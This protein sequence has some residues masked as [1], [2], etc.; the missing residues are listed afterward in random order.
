MGLIK[1]AMGATGGVLA[2][3]WKEFFYLES[4]PA[5]VLVSKGQ[6]R[7]SGR[8]SNIRGEENIITSGSGIAVADG[9]A[10]IIVEQGKI[11]DFCAE[12]GHYTFDISG[13]PSLFA[14]GSFKDNAVGS[15]KSAWERFKF[16]GIPG[17]DTRVYYF[18]TKELVGNRYGTPNPV[19]FRVV[20]TNIGLDIDISIRCFGEYSYQ[21]SNP[22]LFYT[23][24]TGN[25]GESYTRDNL[26]GQLKSELMTALQPAFAKISAMGIRYSALP[27]HTAEL[28]EALNEV[29]SA[30]WKELRGIE[31]ISFGVSSVKANE[32]D[33][34]LI[35]ELQKS[36]VMRDPTMAGAALVGAQADAMRAAASNEGGALTGFMGLGMAQQSGGGGAGAQNL[37]AMGQK[38]QQQQPPPV[39]SSPATSGWSCPKCEQTGNSGK[40]CAEC[41]E[42]KPVDGWSCSCGAINKGKF[43][44]ECGK[45]KQAGTPQYKCDKCGWEPEE[46][47]NPP[48][49]CPECGDPF[50]EEDQI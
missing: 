36:A 32:E 37:F 50:N 9:Q 48:K 21:I 11:L 29:L 22:I 5:D 45:P 7:V 44:A 2:D 17:K 18:N 49:F 14:G 43:C 47:N 31:I 41:G 10:M 38:Q 39:A 26:D 30:K 20:D 8:S 23:N 1:A 34:K 12:P 46:P 15:L 6:K 3:Q 24:V 33:E 13:E 42:P 40:F 27:G 19:P 4:M 35:K 16:G 25:V 28:A